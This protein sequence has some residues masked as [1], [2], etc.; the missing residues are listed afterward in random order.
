MEEVRTCKVCEMDKPLNSTQFREH[1]DRKSG[2]VHFSHTCRKCSSDRTKHRHTLPGIK[3]LHNLRQRE[4]NRR[5]KEEV[6]NHYGGKCECCGETDIRFL[7]LDHLE[8]GGRKDREK[9]KKTMSSSGSYY[10]RWLRDTGYPTHLRVLCFNCNC[11][12]MINGGVCP[13]KDNYQGGK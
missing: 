3:E 9:V 4:S 12:R 10:Y 13:H 7:T 6:L 11:G 1:T 5:L 2:K 8:G